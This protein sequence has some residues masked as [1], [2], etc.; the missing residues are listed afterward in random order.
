MGYY[1]HELEQF[2][3]YIADFEFR[4]GCLDVPDRWYCLS[5]EEIYQMDADDLDPSQPILE[6]WYACPVDNSLVA[7]L[8][9]FDNHVE[10]YH[11]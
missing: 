7:L 6:E 4:S 5:C 8:R 1:H 2:P 11:C 10:E 3:D 9:E